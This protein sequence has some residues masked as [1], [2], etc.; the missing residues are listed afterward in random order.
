MISFRLLLIELI[1][2]IDLNRIILYYTDIKIQ[3]E[4]LYITF[5]VINNALN[6]TLRQGFISAGGL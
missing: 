1:Y 5:I 3:R 4:I 6:I 2:H